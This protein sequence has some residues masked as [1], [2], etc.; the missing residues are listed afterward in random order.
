MEE[1]HRLNLSPYTTLFRSNR[2]L[3][4]HEAVLKAVSDAGLTALMPEQLPWPEQLAMFSKA[5]IVAGEF[6]S[7]LHN[8]LFSGRSEEHTSELQS[9]V[10]LVCSIQLD[11]KN[12]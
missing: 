4:N 11:K 1:L 2:L 8:T 5:R 10:H 3:L 6:G 9:L 7:G 12:Q